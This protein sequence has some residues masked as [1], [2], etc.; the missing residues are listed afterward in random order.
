MGQRSLATILINVMKSRPTTRQQQL[1]YQ[2]L[3]TAT[4][5]LLFSL[6]FSCHAFVVLQGVTTFSEQTYTQ[7]SCQ[8][9]GNLPH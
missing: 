4:L 1:L 3:Q 7:Q 2:P 8:V 6:S 5:T 9:L